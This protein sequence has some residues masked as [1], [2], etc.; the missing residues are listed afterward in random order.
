[1]TKSLTTRWF[2][3]RKI[4]NK[5]SRPN[6]IPLNSVIRVPIRPLLKAIT[7]VNCSGLLWIAVDCSGL[8]WIT[9]ACSGLQ[10][11]SELKAF[12]LKSPS[13][14]LLFPY[15]PAIGTLNSMHYSRL[16]VCLHVWPYTPV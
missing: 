15:L 16:I 14:F 2:T 6:N 10:F 9:V 13:C 11:H 12:L 7:A 8:Q 1:M 4:N 5:N 3:A